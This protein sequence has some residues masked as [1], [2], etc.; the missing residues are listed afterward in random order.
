MLYHFKDSS[1]NIPP[2]EICPIMV[3]SKHFNETNKSSDRTLV[4]A[5]WGMIPKWHVGDYKKH[6]L[7]TNN[8]RLENLQNSKL[9]KPALE[10]GRRCV[11]PVEGF[12]EWNTT[13]PKLKSSE[14]SVF[15]IYNQQKVENIKDEGESI[16]SC[17]NVNLMFLG[18]LYDVWHD[19]K[20]DSIY[21]FTVITFES[22]DY[23][24]WLHHRTPVIFE[25]EQQ[26]R[27]WL[28]YERTPSDQALELIRHPTNII[29]HEVSKQVNSSRNKS[30]SCNK[31]YD[32]ND[33]KSRN[34]LTKW[35]SRKN[36][37]PDTLLEDD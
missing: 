23:F 15:Y 28:D 26:I 25:S 7:T 4:P 33:L 13:N 1:H 19:E 35:I 24:N 27:D 20:G 10:N 36:S 11:I 18:G 2:G 30:E 3:S 34:S 14:R 5:L 16:L 22:N 31:P 21:N 29:W 6:G 12:Y 17:E 32:R 8:A 37:K 9:F